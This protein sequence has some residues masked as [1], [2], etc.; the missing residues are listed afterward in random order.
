MSLRENE[1]GENEKVKPLSVAQLTDLI[2]QTLSTNPKLKNIPVYGEI[3]EMNRHP[4][5]HIYF[6]L[7]EKDTGEPANKKS[8]IKCTFFRYYNKTLNFVPKKGVEVIVKG[9]INLYAPRGEYSLNIV[10]MSE[11]GIG[12]LF[13]KIQEIKRRLI[14]EGIIDPN[15]RRPLPVLPQKIGLITGT[16]TAALRDIYKQ[17]KDRYENVNVLIAPVRVQGESAANSVSAALQ[18]LSRPKWNCDLIIIARGGGSPEDLLPFSDETLARMIAKCDVPVVTGIGHQVD[19]PICDDVADL[20]AATPTDAAKQALPD[21][22][23]FHDSLEYLKNKLA[24]I[25]EMNLNLLNEKIKRF[26]E[27]RVFRDPFSLLNDYYQQLDDIE[28]RFYDSLN[29][30]IQKEKERL[31]QTPDFNHLLEL[32]LKDVS[33]RLGNVTVRIDAYSPLATLKR[34]YSVTYQKSKI[35]KKLDDLNQAEEVEVRLIDGS[36]KAQPKS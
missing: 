34:G 32:R 17:I 7:S 4:S 22:K 1:K 36:F 16:A 29:R 15:N 5:G 27:H 35:V 26:N 6:N 13:L 33:H 12:N 9:S 21:V 25:I 28:L 10:S 31:G 11:L 8:L 14:D 18:E 30:K 2:E 23:T 20:A 19:H 3:T 24:N